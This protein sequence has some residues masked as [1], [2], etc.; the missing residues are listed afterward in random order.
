MKHLQTVAFDA[1]MTLE[2]GGELPSVSCAFETWGT[3]NE[4]ASNAILVC[5]A[6]SGDSHAAKH[7]PED[8]LSLIHI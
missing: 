3:L 2:L 5:H 7:D 4:D 1:P 8:D 6:I